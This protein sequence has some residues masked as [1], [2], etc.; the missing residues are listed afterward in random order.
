MPYFSRNEPFSKKV[1]IISSKHSIGVEL[2]FRLGALSI[3]LFSTIWA[4]EV[5]KGQ[6]SLFD[7]NKIFANNKFFQEHTVFLEYMI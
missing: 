3:G 6:S 7:K 5:K 2:L 4:L 1:P